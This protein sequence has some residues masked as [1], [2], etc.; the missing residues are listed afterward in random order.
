MS[1]R[2]GLRP[3]GRRLGLAAAPPPPPIFPMEYVFTEGTIS[4]YNIKYDDIVG[5]GP[6][7]AATSEAADPTFYNSQRKVV[8]ASDGTLYVVYC[9][10]FVV[11]YQIYVKKSTDGGVTWTDETRISTYAGMESYIQFYP[12]IAVD[13]ID[14][15][16]VVWMGKA[17]GYTT[18]N[19]IWYAKYTTSW[20]TPVRISTYAGMEGYHQFYPSIA[21]DSID[22]LHV[23]WQGKATGYTD[24]NKVWYAKYE[25]SWDAPTVLQS[26]GQNQYPNLRW[27]RW[28]P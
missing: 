22:Y 15:L 20:A 25:A 8:R 28:P 14:Y 19:Q 27:S 6:H 12:S 13:S 23:V 26:T 9:K 4:P 21:V 5:S 1:I 3:M 10:L 2:V 11:R 24:Y 16:H 17:T 7:T 18:I